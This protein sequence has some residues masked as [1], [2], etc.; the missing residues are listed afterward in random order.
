VDEGTEEKGRTKKAEGQGN[1]TEL[2]EQ[3]ERGKETIGK[4]E[5]TEKQS[6]EGIRDRMTEKQ[7]ET[8]IQEK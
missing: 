5:K 8:G 1:I 3:R 7:V 2:K 4:E 6:K